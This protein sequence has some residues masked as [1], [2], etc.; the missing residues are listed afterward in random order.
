MCEG[1]CV[2]CVVVGLRSTETKGQQSTLIRLSQSVTSVPEAP[3]D[4]R[5]RL[6][7]LIG[8]ESLTGALSNS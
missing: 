4:H 3:G 1:L 6:H 5:S 8:K 7:G 2:L